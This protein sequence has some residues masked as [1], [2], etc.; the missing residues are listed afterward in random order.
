MLAFLLMGRC[1]IHHPV[2]KNESILHHDIRRAISAA[3]LGTVL[4][5]VTDALFKLLSVRMAYGEVIF[6]RGIIFLVPAA[7]LIMYFNRWSI[8]RSKNWKLQIL[9]GVVQAASLFLLLEA[10]ARLPLA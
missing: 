2:S 1:Q 10:L 4:V 6:F 9:R 5:T 8:L 3:L 7:V